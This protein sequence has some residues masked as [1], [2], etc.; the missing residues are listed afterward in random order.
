MPKVR[1]GKLRAIAA[2]SNTRSAQVRDLPTVAEI[3]LPGYDDSGWFG[4]LAPAGTNAHSVTRLHAVI[5]KGISTPDARERLASLGEICVVART[6][7][8]GTQ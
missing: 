2:T 1:A 7:P 5:V 6:R 8:L 4:A 3:G